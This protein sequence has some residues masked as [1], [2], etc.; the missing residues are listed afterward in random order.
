MNLEVRKDR[1]QDSKS[2]EGRDTG[3]EIGIQGPETDILFD[4]PN[5]ILDDYVSRFLLPGLG[6][7]TL[8][9]LGDS[10]PQSQASEHYN[11]ESEPHNDESE[12]PHDDDRETYDKKAIC[13]CGGDYCHCEEVPLDAHDDKSHTADDGLDGSENVC[14][15]V[16]EGDIQYCKC[17]RPIEGLDAGDEVGS[18]EAKD[19]KAEDEKVED[20]KAE[21]KKVEDKKAEDKQDEDREEEGEEDEDEESDDEESDDEEEEDDD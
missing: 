19:E 15:C 10:F 11:D 9:I 20:E 16:K 8:D 6:P 21:D 2:L 13:D 7:Q 17:D 14:R 18:S 4:F 5:D 3:L 12:P 1:H